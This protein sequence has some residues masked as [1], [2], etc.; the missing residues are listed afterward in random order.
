MAAE[1]DADTERVRE[2]YSNLAAIKGESYASLVR[3]VVAT[4]AILRLM[5]VD[6]VELSLANMFITFSASITGELATSYK[7]DIITPE[8]RAE[9]FKNCDGMDPRGK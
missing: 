9:F 7:V 5:K 8:A 1:L 3:H 6:E 4:R 2:I